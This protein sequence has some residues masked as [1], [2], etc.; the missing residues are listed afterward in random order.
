MTVA[1][2]E[3]D[4]EPGTT[5]SHIRT[6]G[7]LKLLMVAWLALALYLLLSSDRRLA[8]LPGDDAVGHLALF[9]FVSLS[10]LSAISPRTGWR[11]T[12]AAISIH[13]NTGKCITRKNRVANYVALRAVDGQ[14]FPLVFFIIAQVLL[15]VS[16]IFVS[17]AVVGDAA[18]FDN[19]AV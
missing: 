2:P 17:I 4:A 8:N 3:E 12:F 5:E 14:T 10:V 1:H 6:N 13:R 7:I 15:P 18:V 11:T 9:A 16:S 19:C